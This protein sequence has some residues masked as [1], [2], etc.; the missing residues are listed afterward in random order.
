MEINPLIVLGP[1]R[2]FTTV[3]TAMLGQHP[4]MYGFPETYLLR[5][6]TMAEWS[7]RYSHRFHANGLLRL[8]AELI[9]HAQTEATIRFAR[10][11]LA[12]RLNRTAKWV[13]C[14]LAGRVWPRIPVD[15]CPD[16]VADI[17]RM[18]LALSAF[19]DARFLH[20]TRH[21]VGQGLSLL[22]LLDEWM[23]SL[24]WSRPLRA[25]K[26]LNS[27]KS[28]FRD[29]MDWSAHP[30]TVDPQVRWFKE[31]SNILAFLGRVRPSHQ[32]RVRGEDLLA[33][34]ERVLPNL[35]RWLALRSDP[36]AIECMAHPERSPFASVGPRNAQ[37]G[38]D[39]HFCLEPALRARQH[40]RHSLNGPLPWRTD[41]AG[42][43][44][45]VRRLAEKLGYD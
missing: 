38:Q 45:D 5:T 8:I 15:K 20:V 6:G 35:T 2:S 16:M 3:L 40:N 44:P 24:A 14:E 36:E 22:R 10:T 1:A 43:K 4:Q 37:F 28:V 30:P 11:W 7:R 12:C 25:E 13:F 19:P 34:P 42:L 23:T 41:R 32:F 17:G 33:S 18:D 9:A 26:F 39:P 21:P 29:M 27:P 31:H